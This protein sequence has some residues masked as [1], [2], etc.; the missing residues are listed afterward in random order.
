MNGPKQTRL[1]QSTA[2]RAKQNAMVSLGW[3]SGVAEV[4]L[5]AGILGTQETWVRIVCIFL[6][7]AVL[8]FYAYVYHY[9]MKNDPD[10]LQTEGYNLLRHEMTLL[11]RVDSDVIT[12]EPVGQTKTSGSMPLEVSGPKQISGSE[13]PG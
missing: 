2:N 8:G 13:T 3:F 4:V 11:G 10:R 7:V 1:S 9:F 6:F 12:I 5:I